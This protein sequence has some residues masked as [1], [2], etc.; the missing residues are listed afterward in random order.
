VKF[1]K[2]I[3]LILLCMPVP[4]M[5]SALALFL[6][7]HAHPGEL[8]PRWISIPML[9]LLI[10]TIGGG[11]VILTRTAR[12]HARLETPD[13]GKLRRARTIKGL[14]V[15]LVVWILI[16][17]NDIRLL[18]QHDVPWAYGIPALI[19]IALMIAVFWVSRERL[20]KIDAADPGQEQTPQ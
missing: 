5:L 9:C 20:K 7:I 14:K 15:G 8:V 3:A 6:Y 11:S 10:L 4:L 13:E 16:L 17:L 19:I 2:K 1:E 18:A 12:R